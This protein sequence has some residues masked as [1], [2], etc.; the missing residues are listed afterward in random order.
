MLVRR[1]CPAR[2]QRERGG[3]FELE[4]D[5]DDTLSVPAS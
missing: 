3:D 4:S 5:R 1:E 2:N